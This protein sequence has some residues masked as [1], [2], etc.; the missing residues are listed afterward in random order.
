MTNRE[1][2]KFDYFTLNNYRKLLEL[3]I[4]NNF[5]FIS[6]PIILLGEK[7]YYLET[8]CGFFTRYCIRYG[9]NRK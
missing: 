5:Q 4:T 6:F 2:Y 8:L 7:R 9:E 1:K 3:A